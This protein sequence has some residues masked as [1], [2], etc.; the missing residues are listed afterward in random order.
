M[1]ARPA[2]F[3]LTIA[4]AIAASSCV[5][6]PAPGAPGGAPM[7]VAYVKQHIGELHGQTIRMRGEVNNCTSLTC[8]ICDGPSEQD[9]CLGLD[10]FADSRSA[11]YL[12]EE[13]YRFATITIDARIDAS[14][15]VNYDPD[16]FRSKVDSDKA[17]A[18]QERQV[19]V[20]CTDR[21]SSVMDARVVRVDARKPATQGRFNMYTGEALIEASSEQLGRVRAFLN[22][23]PWN[24]EDD[25]T[26]LKL[27]IDSEPLEKGIAEEYI[28]C[29]CH[30]DDCTGQ[31][32]TMA[33]H[34]YTRTPANPYRC[35]YITRVG[36]VW[37][38]SP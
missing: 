38:I 2:T 18:R 16:Q 8:K 10:L 37:V 25:N 4:L 9:A 17:A 31:W 27:F 32:P 15:E 3:S 26:Q 21:A 34:A 35:A 7:T 28:F 20:I 19:V 36:E 33:H 5:S 6:G 13:L 30:E 22:Q 12:V 23:L 11:S 1:V 24:D 29:E 14:C